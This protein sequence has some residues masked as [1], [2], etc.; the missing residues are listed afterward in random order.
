MRSANKPLACAQITAGCCS[1]VKTLKIHAKSK[2]ARTRVFQKY[3]L[4]NPIFAAY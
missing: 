1:T 4:S 2:E 3:V